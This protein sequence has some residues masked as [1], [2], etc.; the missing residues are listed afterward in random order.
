MKPDSRILVLGARGLVGS[1]IVRKL[2]SVGYNNL[3]L[4]TH[5]DLDLLDGGAVTNYFNTHKPEYVFMCAAK[6]GGIIANN[7]YRADFIWENLQIM[8]CVFS[9]WEVHVSIPNFLRNQ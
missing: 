6:V 7:T 4:P 9:L 5:N 8:S 2:K 1:S 3:Y